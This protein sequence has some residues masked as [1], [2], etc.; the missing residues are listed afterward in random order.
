MSRFLMPH[1]V[2]AGYNPDLAA[3]VAYSSAVGLTM[4]FFAGADDD[5]KAELVAVFAPHLTACIE[6]YFKQAVELTPVSM[7]EP[8]PN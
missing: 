6:C 3:E 7:P 8:S 1:P 2:T 4:S 5:R